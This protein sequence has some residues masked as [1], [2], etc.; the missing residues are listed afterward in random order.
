MISGV[1]GRIAR[2]AVLGLL[3]LPAA[4]GLGQRRVAGHG[5]HG[6]HGRELARQ[7]RAILA[8]PELAQAHFG[9]RITDL[10][11]RVLF[12]Q[13]D[14]QLFVP[15]SNA[16]LATTAAAFALLPVDTLTWT[17]NVVSDG[18]LD[19]DGTLR[20][21]LVLAGAGDPNL[22][23]R[24]LPYAPHTAEAGNALGAIE[25]LADQVVKAGVRTVAG[26][27]LG[28]DTLFPNEPYGAN[29]AWDD[30]AWGYGA[31]VS[32]LSVAD[33]EVT[34]HLTQDGTGKL[35]ASWTPAV[36]YYTLRGGMTA[37][38]GAKAEPGLDRRPGSLTVRAWGTA[39]A[40]GFR[41][42]MAI[43]DPAEFAAR[44]LAQALA[45]RGVTVTGRVRALHRESTVTAD[46]RSE[47]A[48]PLV[49]ARANAG[50]VAAP[51]EGRRVLAT[52]VSQPM[53]LDLTVL[54]KVSQNLHAE[55]TLRAL[56]RLLAADGSFAQGARVVRQFLVS[57]GVAGDDFFFYDGSGM[58][59]A[60]L[61][62]PRAYTQLLTYAARQGWGPA[63]RAT[64]PVGGVD[65]TLAGRFKGTAL[66]GRVQ[67]KTGTLGEANALSG[68][69]TAASGKTL[70]FSI[71][72]D[73]HRP[74]S[75]AELHAID[76]ICLAAAAV[77]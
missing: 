9:I 57:A 62:T 1:H 76:R 7:V 75:S 5:R 11:G 40:Q 43:E 49:L 26:D 51:L 14:A 19:G 60:D 13:N 29:W 47:Q 67:A 54:N 37:V 10:N 72:V 73:S 41:A 18:A 6:G 2:L 21:N 25:E 33:N 44:A 58:S 59:S 74:G 4:M 15:A 66:E 38:D 42:P 34:L 35:A 64:F 48:E 28:D 68:Y 55:L 16:K 50:T 70:V 24:T 31:P 63:W 53:A 12:A 27:V 32:A 22:S 69:L 61:I 8:E 36:P 77:E 52:H 39:D 20:G 71:L 23:G 56:G 45:A 65:G 17:T 3:V 30:L 46:S